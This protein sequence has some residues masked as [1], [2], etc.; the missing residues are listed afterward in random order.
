MNQYVCSI[1][2]YIHDETVGGK[3]EDLPAD[4]QIRKKTFPATIVKKKFYDKHYKK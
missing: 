1:C 3:W 4:L 2:G